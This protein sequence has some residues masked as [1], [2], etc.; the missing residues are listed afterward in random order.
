VFTFGKKMGYTHEHNQRETFLSSSMVEHAAVNRRVVGS[1]P[2][3][4]VFHFFGWGFYITSQVSAALWLYR[5]AF[6]MADSLEGPPASKGVG[7][8]A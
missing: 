4:G 2:T 1:N 3:W 6:C 8:I 7:H 5:F